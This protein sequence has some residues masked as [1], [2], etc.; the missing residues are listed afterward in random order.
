MW[1]WVGDGGGEEGICLCV[2]LSIC[3]YVCMCVCL[4]L[5]LSLSLSLCVCVCVCVAVGYH[6]LTS[7]LI[8]TWTPELDTHHLPI[9]LLTTRQIPPTRTITLPIP[10]SP[11][12]AQP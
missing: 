5:S 7:K 8:L 10:L 3:M 11:A 6:G 4:S 9:H 2:Y 1:D 12:L